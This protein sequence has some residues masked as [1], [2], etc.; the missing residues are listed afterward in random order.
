[1]IQEIITYPIQPSAEY[2]T[3][4]RIFNEDI[5]SLLEDLKDTINANNLEALAAFQIGSYY[6]V[7]V[8][9]EEDGNFIEL[10]NPRL[11]STKGKITSTEK[12]SY[13]PNLSAIITRYNQISIVYQDRKSKYHSLL[14]EGDRS[15]L[16]Q[17]KLDYNFGAT[18]LNKMSK[19][20]KKQFEKKLEFGSNIIISQSCPTIFVRDHFVNIAKLLILIMFLVIIGSLFVS[21]NELKTILFNTQI[22]L[23]FG[24]FIVYVGYFLYAHYESKKY[25]SCI[26]CQSGNIIGTTLIGF[27]KITVLMVISYLII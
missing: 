7:V 21:D 24:A 1:M 14:L 23:S 15:V 20:E 3:D 5:F 22:Y 18:F 4:V 19:E 13:F 27:A 12:T 17:R 6:N 10:I 25:T 26:S 11:I 2:G 16:L 8:L 9:Q